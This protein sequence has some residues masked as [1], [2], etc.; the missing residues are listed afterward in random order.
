M[1]TRRTIGNRNYT[2]EFQRHDGT[3]DDYG[4]PTYD[5][6]GDWDAVISDWPCELIT[7]VG[8][9]IIRGKMTMEKSTHVLYGYYASVASVDV[10]CRVL[11]DGNY[12]GITAGP[13]D[14]DGRRMEARLEVRRVA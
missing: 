12:Y 5:V 10:Q 11:I 6:A 3:V 13:I 1:P 7:T 4:N 9:E 2:A 14:P 8:G